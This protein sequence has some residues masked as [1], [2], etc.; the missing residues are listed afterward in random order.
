MIIIIVKE[1]EKILI[2]LHPKYLIQKLILIFFSLEHYCM[3]LKIENL[4]KIKLK[5]KDQIL[6]LS[7]LNNKKQI[8]KFIDFDFI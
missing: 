6:R 8:K 5:N 3:I 4:L 2:T 7:G 1:F